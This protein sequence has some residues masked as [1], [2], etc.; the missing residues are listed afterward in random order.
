MAGRALAFA[1]YSQEGTTTLWN[2]CCRGAIDAATSRSIFRSHRRCAA[3]SRPG[4]GKPGSQISTIEKLERE[5]GVAQVTVRQAVDLLHDEGLVRRQQGRGTFVSRTMNDT[6]WLRF[7]L[8]LSSLL[9]TIEDNVP[10]FLEVGSR[11]ATAF[12]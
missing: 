4:T 12:A 7:E 9:E 2:G 3:G 6:R 10:K 5:F 8:N 11:N 1:H